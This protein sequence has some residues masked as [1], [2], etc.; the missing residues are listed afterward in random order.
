MLALSGNSVILHPSATLGPIDPQI[1]G[2]PARAIKNG[3][4]KAKEKIKEEGPETLPAYIPLIEKYSLDLLEMCEDSENLSRELVSNWLRNYM[5]KD[6]KNNGRKI[7][8]IV[9]FFTN[10]DKHKMHSRALT[11]DKMTGYGLKVSTADDR[12]Q[13]LLWEIYILLSGFFNVSPFVKLYENTHG[14]SWGKQFQQVILG[15]QPQQRNA[16]PQG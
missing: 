10:Y 7:R 9:T 12:L 2:I 1:N 4:E 5:F 11:I 13:E 15:P 14:V 3:F 8:K 16:P 6:E